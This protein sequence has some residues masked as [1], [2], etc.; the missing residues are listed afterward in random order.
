M[1]AAYEQT[2]NL[3]VEELIGQTIVELLAKDVA[4]VS[5]ANTKQ[6]FLGGVKNM[7][8]GPFWCDFSCQGGQGDAQGVPYRSSLCLHRCHVGMCK[9]CCS[10]A[11]RGRLCSH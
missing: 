8:K 2:K 6:K 5:V 9:R 11:H 3:E 10:A 7:G 1:G 4:V